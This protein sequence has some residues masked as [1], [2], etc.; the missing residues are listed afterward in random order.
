MTRISDLAVDLPASFG[1]V[2]ACVN[3][4]SIEHGANWA[5]VHEDNPPLEELPSGIYQ[6]QLLTEAAVL[7]INDKLG[8][9]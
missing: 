8:G 3:Q 7:A 1:E 2:M 6:N 5:I 9:F 4:L